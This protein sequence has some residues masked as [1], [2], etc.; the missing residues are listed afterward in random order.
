M[1]T[2]ETYLCVVWVNVPP[3]TSHDLLTSSCPPSH[4]L[5][6]KKAFT[7]GRYLL[8]PS[9]TQPSQISSLPD[10]NAA[11]TTSDSASSGALSRRC[12]P[13]QLP[14]TALLRPPAMAM[15]SAPLHAAGCK[16]RCHRSPA[17]A[18]PLV[19][20]LLPSPHGTSPHARLLAW[21]W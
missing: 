5:Q 4:Y 1:S 21:R 9:T 15:S 2:N 6:E 19:V 8:R 14:H 18:P 11:A 16:P 13:D 12:S 10:H 7:L 3:P 20:A 17:P